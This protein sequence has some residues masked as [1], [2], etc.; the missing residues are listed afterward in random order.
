MTVAEFIEWLKVQDQSAMVCV[1]STNPNGGEGLYE[2]F[3][4]DVHTDYDSNSHFGPWLE[5]GC[6][7]RK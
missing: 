1:L 6:Q 5:L 7:Y 2:R 3:R 4:P